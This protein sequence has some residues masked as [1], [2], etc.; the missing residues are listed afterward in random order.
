MAVQTTRK[1]VLLVVDESTSG[2]PVAPSA[3]TDA[4]ALQ[5]GFS[6]TPAF[7]TQENAELRSS[8]GAAAPIQ[9]L[10]QPEASIDHYIRHSGVEGQEPNF[11]N[12]LQSIFGAK[13]V[14]ATQYSTTAGSTAGT[15]TVRGNL[16]STGNAANFQR[17]EGLLIKDGVN[18]YSVRNVYAV[19]TADDIS[20]SFNLTS[21]PASGVGLG[22]AVLYYPADSGENAMS[23]WCYRGNGGAVELI[24][25]AKTSEMSM[26]VTVGELVNG[27]FS[28]QG[29]AYYFNP[30]LITSST[31]YLDF[32]DDDGTWAVT[33]AVKAYKDPHDLASAL[34]TAMNSSGTTETHSVVYSDSTGKYTISTSTSAVLSLLWNTGANTAN[35]IATKV[36]FTTAADSTG[37]LTYTSPNAYVLT[38][39]FTPSYDSS[40]PI[41]A[42]YAEV[43]MGDFDDFSCACVQSLS[44]SLSKELTDVLCI[45][46]ESGVSDQIATSR[47]VT[48]EVVANLEPYDADKFRR[49]RS[50]SDISF[51]FNF[52]VRN[53]ANWVAGK[54]CNLYIPTAKISDFTLDDA[55]GIVVM[56]FTITAYVD[57]SG[58]GEVYMNFL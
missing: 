57:S 11:G 31:R 56:S 4:V 46:S 21:A 41:A 7:D 44:F 8:I 37:A 2:T 42:K 16:K 58:N 14:N 18:G 24:S 9:G 19:P 36:G 22:K 38:V 30:V 10:E 52:G 51:A 25:G 45:C 40:D 50:N 35:S 5:D 43:M 55:D 28:F 34:Q 49:F 39:P 54:T 48:I 13:Q 26:D 3:G 32:V 23:L 53:G 17:G 29:V 47:E 27:A 6:L 12:F 33:V 15:A 20:L 1:S